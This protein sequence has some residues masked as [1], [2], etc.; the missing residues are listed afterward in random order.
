MDLAVLND[1]ARDPVALWD[2]AGELA[3]QVGRDVDLVDLRK[4]ST[5][6]QHQI[7]TKGRRLFSADSRA[8]L[9]EAFILSEKTALDER[10]A[11]LM[12]DIVREGRVY[13]R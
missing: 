1:G 11:G 2:Q 13:G 12:Q 4:A 6:F 5:V 3:D 7:V 10:R 8:D 9:Y